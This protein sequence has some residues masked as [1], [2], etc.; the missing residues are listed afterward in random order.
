M[1]SF[2]ESF[3]TEDYDQE[4]LDFIEENYT[5][6]YVNG[7]EIK[8]A[9][10]HKVHKNKEFFVSRY[11]QHYGVK[12]LTKEQFKEK[13]GMTE[14]LTKK[15]PSYKN[16][17]TK[18]MLVAGKHVVEVNSS[19]GCKELLNVAISE[20][21]MYL[22]GNDSVFPVEVFEDDI[23]LPVVFASRMEVWVEEIYLIESPESFRRIRG[24]L[25][26][27]W[28]RPPEKSKAQFH[29]DKCKEKLEGIQKMME[30]LEKEILEENS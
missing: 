20:E 22:Q 11:T 5:I 15:T 21:G 16:T 2:E 8:S 9:L 23:A 7:W 12:S 3:Y 28:K 4:M 26:S 10:V 27:I 13:I 30:A 1:K 14:N 17:F 6:D 29:Y 19:V 24:S 18:D 25:K